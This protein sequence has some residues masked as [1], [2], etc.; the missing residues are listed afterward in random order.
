[1]RNGFFFFSFEETETVFTSSLYAESAQAVT[2]VQ[3]KG[4]GK[5][6]ADCDYLH[7]SKCRTRRNGF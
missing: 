2:S 6:S 1:M 5:A 4:T 3:A 7:F